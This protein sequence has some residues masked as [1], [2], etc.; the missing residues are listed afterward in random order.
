MNAILGSGV[1]ALLAK[2]ILGADWTIVPFGR[3]RFYSFNPPLDDNFIIVDKE[4][5]EIIKSLGYGTTPIWYKRSFSVGGQLSQSKDLVSDWLIRVFGSSYPS[6]ALPYLNDRLSGFF[7][8]GDVRTNKLYQSLQN[9][10]A[11][12]IQKQTALGK[13]TKIKDKV[14]YRDG[15][16]NIEFDNLVSTIPLNYLYSLLGFGH[17]LTYKDIHCVH[18]ATTKLDFE[19]SMQVMLVNPPLAF[20][21]VSKISKSRYLFYMDQDV[22][23]IGQY[24]MPVLEDFDL[25]D[26]TLIPDALPLGERSDLSG[27]EAHGIFCVGSYAQ[28]DWCCDVG[29][30]I[31]RLIRYAQ[32]DLKP[33]TSIQFIK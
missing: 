15:G 9:T 5:D 27:L 17:D 11:E 21:K 10:Y 20:Y 31:L 28:H 33:K 25:L 3:S 30:N 14:I 7:V 2:H 24:L 26:G 32:R 29:S 18:L 13:V 23:N 8:Y 12:E 4:I 22:P 16:N 6:Q 1:V 19:G